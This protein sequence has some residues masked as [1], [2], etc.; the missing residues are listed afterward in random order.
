MMFR[1]DKLLFDPQPWHW[2]QAKC[3]H[4]PIPHSALNFAF[5]SVCNSTICQAMG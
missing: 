2:I 4:F 1:V 5:N 3:W